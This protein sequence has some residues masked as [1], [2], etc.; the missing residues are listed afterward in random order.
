MSSEFSLP[1]FAKVNLHLRIAG[2]RADGFHE[3]CTVFQAISLRDTL[4][5]READ[6]LQMTCSDASIPVD[7]DNIIM[8][9]AQLLEE[10]VGNG[11]GADIHLQKRIPSPGGLGGGSSNAAAALIGLTRLWEVELPAAEMHAIA[12]ALGSDVPFFLTG[13]TAMGTGRGE[14]IEPID[15]KTGPYMLVVTPAIDV[16]TAKAY[17]SLHAPNLTFDD[18][19]LILRVCRDDARSLDL[20]LSVLIN[21]FEHSV[22]EAFPEIGE[23]K[24]ELLKLGAVNALLSGSGASVFAV[25]DKEET[26]QAAIKAL[27][28][29][30][31][32]RKFA[33]AA[34]SRSEYREAFR[35]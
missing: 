20:H 15:D 35:R 17:P 13:G 12:A 6:S 16:S 23:V 4:T 28:I 9:A 24:Q 5:F 30:S 21:D 29:R 10:L 8:R 18:P 31:T 27:D 7:S 32:W 2:K 34:V 1:S 25:F 19:D 33:V 22:F 11:R 26:R 14:I 3:I